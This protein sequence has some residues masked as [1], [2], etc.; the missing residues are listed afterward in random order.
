M[1][2]K[3]L[4]AL[5]VIISCSKIGADMASRLSSRRGLLKKI[6]VMVIHLRGEILY[7][8]VPL[9][10][11]FQKAGK[12]AGGREGLLFRTVADRLLKGLG[13]DFFSIWQ[14]EAGAYLTQTPL[15][16]EER[17]QF[18]AFGEHLG[19]LDREMQERTLS[20][21]LEELER[22][23]E[24]LNREIAQKSRLYTSAGILAGLFLTVVFI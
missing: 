3:T 5:L 15:I 18:L 12:R 4:G 6:R 2:F 19:Y 9:Y 23:A 10:E 11:G 8:N 1:L 20:L 22:E 16:R 24:E 14:E 13:D 17:E 7:A 21:Y